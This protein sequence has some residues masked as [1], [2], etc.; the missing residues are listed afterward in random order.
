MVVYNLA[1][2]SALLCFR[3]LSGLTS[4]YGW[5]LPVSVRLDVMRDLPEPLLQCGAEYISH[6]SSIFYLN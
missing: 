6:H 1:K 5:C 3:L 2:L 4:C